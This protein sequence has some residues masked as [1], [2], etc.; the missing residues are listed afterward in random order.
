MNKGIPYHILTIAGIFSA[1]GIGIF[2]GSMLNGEKF[3]VSQQNKLM[4]E[5]RQAF[6]IINEENEQLKYK[7][8]EMDT[9]EEMKD[10]LLQTLYE[11]YIEGKLEGCNIAVIISSEQDDYGEL[12]SILEEAGASISSVYTVE[13]LKDEVIVF[14]E[15]NTFDK[16][17]LVKIDYMIFLSQSEG[18]E[19]DMSILDMAKEFNIPILMVGRFNSELY[20][21]MNAIDIS[22]I[23]NIETHTGKLSLLNIIMEKINNNKIKVEVY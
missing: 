13:N 22:V 21:Q 7:I 2:I 3:M 5:L 17:N 19:I 1:L 4:L 8:S 11:D 14:R 9:E 20:E 6:K 18:H 10:E 23:S 12:Q 16:K 15:D